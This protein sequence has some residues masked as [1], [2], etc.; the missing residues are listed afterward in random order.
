M[1]S[2]AKS[3][4]TGFQINC[5]YSNETN[6][7]DALQGLKLHKSFCQCSCKILTYC[8]HIFAWFLLPVMI[9]MWYVWLV[10]SVKICLDVAFCCHYLRNFRIYSN[11]LHNWRIWRKSLYPFPFFL[12]FFFRHVK[13]TMLKRFHPLLF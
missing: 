1:N 4:A 10:A 11:S 8:S 3:S 7:F 9:A 12:F 2:E 6:S 13:S 5:Q